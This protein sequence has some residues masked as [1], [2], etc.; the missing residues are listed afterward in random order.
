MF[1]RVAVR[2][3]CVLYCFGRDMLNG[4]NWKG[5]LLFTRHLERQ[6][7]CRHEGLPYFGFLVTT[8]QS[9]V[10]LERFVHRPKAK[11]TWLRVYA[12][13][14]RYIETRLLRTPWPRASPS[15]LSSV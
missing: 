11:A 10:G 6:G 5:M 12:V 15:F 7:G 3:F 4:C 1:A 8:E 9:G 2:M 13:K 14:R